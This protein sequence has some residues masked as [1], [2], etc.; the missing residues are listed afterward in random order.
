[1]GDKDAEWNTDQHCEQCRNAHQPQ[2]FAGKFQQLSMILENESKQAH[3]APSGGME[4]SGSPNALTYAIAHRS[5]ERRNSCGG[6]MVT[7]CP[8]SISPIRD[9]SRNASRKSC[10]TKTT[11]LF[12]LL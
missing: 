10:V 6:R 8:A 2:V 7:S 3:G 11:V 9:P 1:M 5:G 12:S 4:S